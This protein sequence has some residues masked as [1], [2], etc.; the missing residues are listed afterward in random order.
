MEDA[1]ASAGEAGG[2]F[3]VEPVARRFNASAV[4]VAVFCPDS[5]DAGAVCRLAGDA[6]N[7]VLARVAPQ[8]RV[9]S[10]GQIETPAAAEQPYDL[11]IVTPPAPRDDP[12]AAFTADPPQ[13]G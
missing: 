6:A 4:E 8:V 9:L 5:A 7:A 11:W 2:V 10:V 3:L 12:C 1:R 13:G